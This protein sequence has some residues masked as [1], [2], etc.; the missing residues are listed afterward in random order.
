MASIIPSDISR[1]ALAGHHTP[2]LA[3]LRMLRASLPNA[4]TVFH[5]V[6]WTRE[7]RGWTHFGEIDFVVLNQSGDVLFIEQKNGVLDE[8][9]AGC[10]VPG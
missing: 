1:M 7:Y 2:E 5:G 4:Y 6:H 9:A 8:T 3:T 10:Y